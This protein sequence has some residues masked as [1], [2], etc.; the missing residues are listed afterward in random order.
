[1]K[2]HFRI[3]S[4]A[5]FLL[6]I[7]FPILSL[8]VNFGLQAFANF[9][10]RTYKYINHGAIKCLDNVTINVSSLTGSGSISAWAN[11]VDI[12]TNY[13]GYDGSISAG[14]SCIIE[15]T[16]FE[17]AA[18]ISAPDVII[19]A[20]TF[21]FTGAIS[22][23]KKCRIYTKNPIDTTMFKRFEK[24]RCTVVISP[25]NA[26]IFDENGLASA[27]YNFFYAN[28]LIL[29]VEEIERQIKEISAYAALN[30]ID[31][32]AAL[33][34]IKKNLENKSNFHKARVKEKRDVSSLYSGLI[35]CGIS[36]AG[37]VIA[38]II[39][40]NEQDLTTKIHAEPG[41]LVDLSA[42]AAILSV[43]PAAFSY[44]DFYNWR[45]PKH[46]E[47]HDKLS[48]IIDKIELALM[49]DEL[50]PVQIITL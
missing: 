4:I 24:G 10:V 5:S 41:A 33:E 43:L 50:P 47:K 17:G 23:D 13:F 38:A 18:T 34:N 26:R 31:E 19:I 20:D 7:Q 39:F 44:P 49:S 45:N 21:K 12:T 37:L 8:Q 28:C 27:Y 9:D 35:K 40:G 29:T 32:K 11:R 46:Q 22:C 6:F 2:K 42:T 14:N 30:F 1:M 16:T 36:A 3:I 48:L 15:A 25:Y